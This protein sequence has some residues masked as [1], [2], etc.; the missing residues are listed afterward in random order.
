MDGKEVLNTAF[1]G[2]GV[3]QPPVS[4]RVTGDIT[5]FIR[6]MANYDLHASAPAVHG[7]ITQSCCRLL[8]AKPDLALRHYPGGLVIETKMGT[9]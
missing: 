5:P 8:L 3:L 1:N 2:E 9:S 4:F 7:S 6:M